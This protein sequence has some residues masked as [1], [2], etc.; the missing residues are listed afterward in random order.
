MIEKYKR[1]KG[2]TTGDISKALQVN[3]SD[4]TRS[5]Y[6]DKSGFKK[7]LGRQWLGNCVDDK[8]WRVPDHIVRDRCLN[9]S[10][11]S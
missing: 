9:S 10:K 7:E 1:N 8:R 2:T 11:V 5:N 6:L 4:R 3:N